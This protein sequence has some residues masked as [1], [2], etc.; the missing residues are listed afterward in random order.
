[1]VKVFLRLAVAA[2]ARR[3]VLLEL[4]GAGLI[5]TGVTVQWGGPAGMI[6]GGGF[7]LVKAFELDLFDGEDE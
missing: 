5:I 6:T 3:V 1:M 7:A 4:A 2:I